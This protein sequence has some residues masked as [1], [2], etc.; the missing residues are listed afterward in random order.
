MS[1]RRIV[2]LTFAVALAAQL[3]ADAVAQSRFAQPRRAVERMRF[4]GMDRN[5]DGVITR[6]EWRGSAQAFADNDWNGDGVLSGEEVR[7]DAQ[8]NTPQDSGNVFGAATTVPRG[9][10]AQ[11]DCVASAPRVVDDIY[12]QVLERPADQASAAIT[13][14]LA[15]GRTTVRDVVRHVATSPEHEERFFWTPIVRAVYQQ[16][17][18]REP[19]AQ[20]LHDAA[21]DLAAGRRELPDFIA[22]AATRAANNQ[23]DAV[24]ILYRRLLGREPDAGGLQAYT[25]MAR[26]DGIEA[27]ARSIVQSPEYRQR[28][29]ADGVPAEDLSAYQNG[30]RALY[31]HVLGRDPDAAGLQSLT[32]VATAGGFDEVVAR[33]LDSPEYQR[34][35]GTDVV[36]GRNVRY[37]GTTRE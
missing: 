18:Q 29:G 22:R 9:T 23:D 2:A 20:E 19:S 17:L 27:V 4:R 37:C 5:N 25:E 7:P 28:A 35:Y 16:I 14:D 3:G 33:M 31:R 15:A 11:G 1:T 26:R 32:R 34:M 30:V 36:P 8:R 12:Q 24:R 6:D 13:Q 21:A 10:A